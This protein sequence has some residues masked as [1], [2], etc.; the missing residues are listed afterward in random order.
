MKRWQILLA[1]G[2]SLVAGCG[3]NNSDGEIPD[4]NKVSQ[5]PETNTMPVSAA[6]QGGQP[7]GAGGQKRKFGLPGR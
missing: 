7:S 5:N 1:I 4:I 3:S 2:A 6:N